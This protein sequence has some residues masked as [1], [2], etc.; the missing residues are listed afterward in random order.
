MK[1]YKDD[2]KHFRTCQK[3]SWFLNGKNYKLAKSLIEEKSIINFVELTHTETSSKFNANLIT[4]FDFEGDQ[5]YN[6]ESLDSQEDDSE[7][8]LGETIADGIET[9]KYAQDYFKR[10]FTNFNL[11]NYD[12]IKTMEIINDKAYDVLFEPRFEY[13]GC[14]TKCDILKRNNVGWDLIE[15]K[16]VT[17]VKEEHMWDLLY[18]YDIL[19]KCGINIVNT[20]IMYINN[21][22][23][24]QETLD[25]D[26][27]FI[28]NGTTWQKSP[29][30][31]KSFSLYDSIQ[32]ELLKY[33][34][35][36]EYQK[37]RNIMEMDDKETVISFLTS[38][39]C[40]ENDTTFCPHIFKFFPIHNTIF[41]LYRLRK[42]KKALW[43]YEEQLLEV[44]DERI[45]P[46]ITKSDLHLRQYDVIK[47]GEKLIDPNKF[48]DLKI[49]YKK[50]QYPVYMYDFETMK[51]AIPKFKNSTPYLQIPFQYSIHVLLS[52]D[53]DFKTNHNIVHY[54]FLADGNNDPRFLLTKN[55]CHDL[56]KI[57]GQGT[58]VAYNQSFEKSVIKKLAFCYPEFKH[59]LAQIHDG[60]IDLQDFFK[61]FKIYKEQFYGSLSI[62]KTLPA[63]EPAFSYE[64]LTIKK[65]DMASEAFRRRVEDNISLSN[66]NHNF[67]DNMLKYCARDTLGMVVLF[68]HIKII[69]E[70]Y[71]TQL[72]N[73]IK[74]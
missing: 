44:N 18:Q 35:Q 58:Y 41:E 72:D 14:I 13:D 22:Y 46:F 49:E 70:K 5:F 10:R 26:E 6:S 19:T 30:T 68:W 17:W 43:Y 63:F 50:Y 24:R 25:L 33:N 15:I 45:W 65:G 4:I 40:H 61:G 52:P 56:L 36:L 21:N 47:N 34:L 69:I 39:Y 38:P 62:K 29:K 11:E 20:H 67:R 8:Y 37:L 42:T 74:K 64:D 55:L 12:C 3:L 48:I 59:Q 27:L 51:S 73:D 54:E 66:W 2:Y 7:F 16:A 9:G 53:F 31:K 28:P 23:V 71:Q 1:I 57:H 32:D 60:T